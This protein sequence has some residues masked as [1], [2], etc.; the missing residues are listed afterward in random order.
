[1]EIETYVHAVWE[2]PQIN[3][4]SKW[5]SWMLV[6]TEKR[7]VSHHGSE[8][9]LT[10]VDVALDRSKDHQAAVILLLNTLRTN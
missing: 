4:R 9:L 3:E 10:V 8:S 5:I 1:M 6:D 2:C 7:T